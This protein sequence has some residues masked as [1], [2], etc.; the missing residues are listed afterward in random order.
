VFFDK[1]AK[2]IF[3][4]NTTKGIKSKA[5]IRRTIMANTNDPEMCFIKAIE[6]YLK[7]VYGIPIN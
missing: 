1:N 3:S 2:G 7:S 5:D 4:F 6:D